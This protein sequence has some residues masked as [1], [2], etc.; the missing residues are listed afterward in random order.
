MTAT[1]AGVS[2]IV[3]SPGIRVGQDQG[4]RDYDSV[5]GLQ[6]IGQHRTYYYQ[7]DCFGANGPVWADML[8]A[9]WK[10]PWVADYATLNALPF[11]PLYA[12]EVQQ[13]N[14]VNSEDQYEQRFMTKLCEPESLDVFRLMVGQAKKFPEVADGFARLGPE[15]V[16]TALTEYLR[17]RAEAGEIRIK[18]FDLA[19]SVFFDLVRARLHFSALLDVT[20]TPT[21]A[22]ISETVERAVNIF[23]GGIEA[24]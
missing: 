6:I 11:T 16:R 8:S 5:N 10:S 2:Y 9:A 7:I 3:I 23:L 21:P 12:D 1:P 19:A 14:I 15:R 17:D 24:I 4:R 18:N 22:E 13:L 20:Y